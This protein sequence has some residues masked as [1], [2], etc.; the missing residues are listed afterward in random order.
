MQLQACGITTK[1]VFV[2]W[3]LSKL[4][5]KRSKQTVYI[6]A[7][8]GN[9]I[10]T[11]TQIIKLLQYFAPPRMRFRLLMFSHCIKSLRS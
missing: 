4:I 5:L 3:I 11:P 6:G 10:N 7:L 8:I 9:R 2:L 1:I